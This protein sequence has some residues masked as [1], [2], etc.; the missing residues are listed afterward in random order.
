MTQSAN[1]IRNRPRVLI[2]VAA[3]TLS[4]AAAMLFPAGANVPTVY[5][6]SDHSYLHI[7]PGTTVLRDPDSGAQ[8]QG[9]VVIDRRTGN[10]WGF[11]TATSAPFP[12]VVSSKE[13]PISKPIYL[14]KFDFAAIPVSAR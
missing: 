2:A 3:A 1:T 8:I 5:A 4:L 14:G 7:E 6:Q 10:V 9:K 11:P 13:P 12:V